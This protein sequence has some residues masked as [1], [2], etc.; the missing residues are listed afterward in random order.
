LSPFTAFLYMM[1]GPWSVYACFSRHGN[2]LQHLAWK[3]IIFIFL[4]TSPIPH[5]LA[6]QHPSI[7][8]I[9]P[10]NFLALFLYPCISSKNIAAQY[11]SAAQ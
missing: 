9:L 11:F 8:A 2:F 6:F 5:L 4:P 3:S 1:Q 7:L 10:M